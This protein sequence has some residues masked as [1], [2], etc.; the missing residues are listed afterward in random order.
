MDMDSEVKT[1]L[2]SCCDE[3]A[4]IVKE[5]AVEYDETV[6]DELENLKTSIKDHIFKVYLVG[7]FS[8]GKSSLLNHWLGTSVLSTGLAPE[9][10]VSSELRFGEYERTILQP[11]K[12]SDSVEELPGVT[13]A[14]MI[15]VRDLANQQRVA[16]VILYM[17]NPR[18]KEYSD[19]CLVDLPG[20]SSAN[21]AHEAALLRFIQDVDRVA[22]FCVPMNDGTIQ[23]DAF[24]FLKK[25]SS[26]GSEP[27]VLL[28]KADERPVSDHEAIKYVVQD[29][30][31]KYGW[32]NAFVG[33]VSKD[34]I[35]DFEHLIKRYSEDKDAFLLQWFG[36]RIRT[37]ADDIRAPLY[38]SL[39][40]QFDNSKIEDALDKIKA[41]E[42]E[43]PELVQEI[44]GEMRM[45]A[46]NAVGEVM[47]KVR[48]SV[49]G[50]QGSLMS[51]A[52]SGLD[53]AAEVASLIRSTLADQAPM[54]IAD[55][56]SSAG[57]KAGALLDER[58]DFDFP[59]E[60][61]SLEPEV[62]QTENLP[63]SS[64]QQAAPASSFA[65]S[66][67]KG[68]T[69]GETA[70]LLGELFLPGPGGLIGTALASAYLFFKGTNADEDRSRRQ[71]EF[72]MK[73]EDACRRTRPDIERTMMEAVDS[74]GQKLRLAVE[75]KVKSL[76]AQMDQLKCE[77]AAGKAEWESRQSVRRTAL[78]RIESA[79]AKVGIEN[80]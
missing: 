38:K 58:L 12:S 78:E 51:K 50:Q 26:F 35:A 55:T 32:K 69:I 8:C 37:L 61:R 80:G 23:E 45:S 56:M 13:E 57:D 79:L 67:K 75:N 47:G 40:A 17:N 42:K 28:T 74:C 68:M 59:K 6:L 70:F 34:S 62:I 2:V 60:P 7:P 9:T 10:A 1:R 44:T 49:M 18:L 15:H 52:E 5:K 71:A 30:L 66:F 19:I 22:I 25:I 48:D 43:L 64:P 29:H 33:K 76:H 24:E 14:N 16:N 54:A 63:I 27:T 11:L 39:A 53:C 31:R 3:L 4:A 73:L 77:A 20:L 36:P 21:P 72:T 65:E 41:T 46:R